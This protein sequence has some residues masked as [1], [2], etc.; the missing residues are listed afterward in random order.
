VDLT[1]LAVDRVEDDEG[2]DLK[3]GDC[4]VSLNRL[5]RR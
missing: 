5:D 2:V 1:W 3:V 4:G